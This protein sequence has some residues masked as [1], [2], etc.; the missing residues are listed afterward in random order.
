MTAYDMAMEEGHQAIANLLVRNGYV[1][2]TTPNVK[3]P[4]TRSA[5]TTGSAP[6]TPASVSAPTA[7]S[8]TNLPAA[9]LA[10]DASLS[11]VLGDSASAAKPRNVRYAPILVD[12]AESSVNPA[13]ASATTT[14]GLSEFTSGLELNAHDDDRHHTSRHASALDHNRSHS[15]TSSLGAVATAARQRSQPS[16]PTPVTLS[17]ASSSTSNPTIVLD[18]DTPISV[19]THEGVASPPSSPHTRLLQTQ[20]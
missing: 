16:S 11:P 15:P 4:S 7:T 6:S 19:S 1:A 14:H 5:S 17:T 8:A 13:L 20:L 3:S 12:N 18:D 2:S 9:R 10:S